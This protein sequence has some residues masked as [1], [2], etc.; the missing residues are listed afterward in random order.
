MHVAGLVEE[1]LQHH[2]VL[3]GDHA[4]GRLCRGQILGQLPGGGGGQMQIVSQPLAGR[5]HPLVQ[6]FR[7]G[8]AQPRYR[9][10]QFIGAPRRLTQPEGQVGRLAAGVFH[11]DLALFD[12]QDTVRG[13]AQLKDI[14][15]HALEGEVLVET[16][17]EKTLRQ[18]DHVVVELI[19]DGAAVG[20]RHQPRALAAAQHAVHRVAVQIGAAPSAMGGEAVG[21]HAHHRGEVVAR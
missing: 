18:Q 16:A 2:G 15:G 19:G 20:D 1:T 9:V 3:G 5:R 17:D 21:Q 7:D 14:A 6:F 4:Q 13:I 10:G 11:V 12:L 8:L